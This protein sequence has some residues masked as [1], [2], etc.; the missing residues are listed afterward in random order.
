MTAQE[1]DIAPRKPGCARMFNP[2]C[3]VEPFESD[4]GNALRLTGECEPVALVPE[5]FLRHVRTFVG[6]ASHERRAVR[7][8][9]HRD[10]GRA[11]HDPL[12][13]HNVRSRP[14]MDHGARGGM[15]Q[16]GHDCRTIL[17]TVPNRCGNVEPVP[18]GAGE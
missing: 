2:Q 15:L 6:R 5:V 3:V 4:T 13:P 17:F 1:R 16:C 7:V 8:T 10:S 14:Q 11:D 12:A 18:V 9:P